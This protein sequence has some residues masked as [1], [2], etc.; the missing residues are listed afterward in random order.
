MCSVATGLSFWAV[1]NAAQVFVHVF[2]VVF[3]GSFEGHLLYMVSAIQLLPFFHVPLLSC[4]IVGQ[5]AGYPG[6]GGT[7]APCSTDIAWAGRGISK[8]VA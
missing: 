3:T 8:A 6:G 5:N 1:R 2:S 7:S 4:H